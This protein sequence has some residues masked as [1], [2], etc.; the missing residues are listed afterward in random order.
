MIF[1][2]PGMK[3]KAIIT[4]LSHQFVTLSQLK[5]DTIDQSLVIG[6][7]STQHLQEKVND[8]LNA[9]FQQDITGSSSTPSQVPVI[10]AIEN[11]R[12]H[13]INCAISIRKYS[14]EAYATT[15]VHEGQQPSLTADNSQRMELR[16]C[17]MHNRRTTNLSGRERQFP[18]FLT[19]NNEKPYDLIDVGHDYLP[20]PV[21]ETCSEIFGISNSSCRAHLLRW[22]ADGFL[23]VNNL[24]P[25]FR[26]LLVRFIT[27]L[28]MIIIRC[29]YPR[30]DDD[31]A[32]IQPLGT[33]IERSRSSL[34]P[35]VSY[36]KE[37]FG[38]RDHR[39]DQSERM[40]VAVSFHT[41]PRLHLSF[42]FVPFSRKND[43]FTGAPLRCHS[44]SHR[45]SQRQT[46]KLHTLLILAGWFFSTCAKRIISLLRWNEIESSTVHSRAR[47]ESTFCG[48]ASPR[49]A[50]PR[51]KI[52]TTESPRLAS[53]NC[54]FASSRKNS[55]RKNI[56]RDC[57]PETL[58][59][60]SYVHS[61]IYEIF[62]VY[63]EKI[64]TK[65]RS[66]SIDLE[67]KDDLFFVE[68]IIF[69]SLRFVSGSGA[70]HRCLSLTLLQNISDTTANSSKKSANATHCLLR[71]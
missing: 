7:E 62:F 54:C 51:G 43:G 66:L 37:S 67:E 40:I 44:N 3:L 6:Q 39:Y 70:H 50:S 71:K 30:A 68:A 53:R 27:I 16:N 17:I 47:N 56:L 38:I 11:R 48:I 36:M 33:L 46:K 58:K 5:A 12:L 55:K 19:D 69:E 1:K 42:F 34:R 61:L 10:E 21:S 28:P 22:R 14:I 49:F 41:H 8:E 32:Q 59:H 2:V 18:S 65:E 60:R 57:N 26:G 29:K 13:M 24:F 4:L 63:L 9:H 23:L 64:L 35:I 25:K 15:N 31:R 52:S 20:S 45:K